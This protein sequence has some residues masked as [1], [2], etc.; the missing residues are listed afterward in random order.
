MIF[1]LFFL[2]ALAAASVALG[3]NE[4]ISS[5]D[6]VR[7]PSEPFQVINELTEYHKGS[8]RSKMKLV[9]MAKEDKVSGRFNNL[10][11][12]RSPPRDAGKAVLMNGTK[13]WFYDPISKASV[14]ISPQQRLLGQASEGDVVTVN[15]A[16]DYE[17]K[18]LAE[19]EK[20]QDA[21]H[22]E[23][24]CW[25]LELKAK[26]EDA[27]YN[28]I[29][30][31]IEKQT[32]HPVKSKFYADS[33]RLLKIAYYHKFEMQLGTLRPTETII[34]DAVDS[35]SV[36]T[37]SFSKLKKIELPDSW[38]QRDYLPRLKADE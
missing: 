8:I 5:S 37:M 15:L 29:E 31:W 19:D 26:T 20:L 1:L 27:I 2:Q 18:M 34:I 7:N 24:H 12:Y 11:L 33:G 22:K 14:R 9:V 3:P 21:D 16:R 23:R 28:K 32:Y 38:F 36:T 17:S 10:V 13:L 6:K 25:H 4:I 35:N 30:T